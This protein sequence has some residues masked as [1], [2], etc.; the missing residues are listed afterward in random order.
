MPYTDEDAKI[1]LTV[2]TFASLFAGLSKVK[3]TWN[4]S[5]DL[6]K[7]A[8]KDDNVKQVLQ[9]W[10]I[11]YPSVKDVQDVQNVAALGPVVLAR[12]KGDE[13]LKNAVAMQQMMQAVKG[14]NKTYAYFLGQNI[15]DNLRSGKYM[16]LSDN[17]RNFSNRQATIANLPDYDPAKFADSY[18]A[19][20]PDN[21]AVI[22][23]GKFSNGKAD[24]RL[25][26]E[27]LDD[28]VNVS[29][30]D[31][32]A[33][34]LESL[35]VQ[36]GRAYTPADIQQYLEDAK[37]KNIKADDLFEQIPGTEMYRA[38]NLSESVDGVL[39]K[40]ATTTVDMLKR[41]KALP[42]TTKTEIS[43]AYDNQY[44]AMRTIHQDNPQA[45][46]AV[47]QLQQSKALENMTMSLEPT[48]KD[49]YC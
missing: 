10:G 47:N 26:L 35:G 36:S 45:V 19:R 44:D 37:T 29:L 16:D 18:I 27:N 31:R 5:E 11:K 42:A 1:D 23:V 43:T 8:L 12:G 33:P 3:K 38:K 7:E 14:E 48:L 4:G 17:V 28:G 21:Q 41:E 24:G 2:S 22:N 34:E 20:T 15:S 30:Q 40:E 25:F 32:I 9:D 39:I 13:I 49:I 46:E 6:M